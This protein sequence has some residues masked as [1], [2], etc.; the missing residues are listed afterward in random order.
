MC[1][2]LCAVATT[3]KKAKHLLIKSVQIQ[4]IVDIPF[5]FSLAATSRAH[6]NKTASQNN[7]SK[8]RREGGRY[9][10]SEWESLS[11]YSPTLDM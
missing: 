11:P 8:G 2:T 4:Y 7:D 10:K 9:P 1:N 3:V 6:G 5:V